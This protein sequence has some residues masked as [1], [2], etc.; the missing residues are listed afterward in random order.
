MP[1]GLVV[2]AATSEWAAITGAVV[3]CTVTVNELDAWLPAASDAEQ[4]TVFAPSENV[5]PDAGRQMTGTVPST[6]SVAVGRE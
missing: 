1:D 5:E 4:E 2:L 3:S 6:S